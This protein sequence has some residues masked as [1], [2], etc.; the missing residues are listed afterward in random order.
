M[1]DKSL[2]AMFVAL[3]LVAF[4]GIAGTLTRQVQLAAMTAKYISCLQMLEPE[5]STGK[6]K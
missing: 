4:F 1:S 6:A 5:L 2:A 3:G